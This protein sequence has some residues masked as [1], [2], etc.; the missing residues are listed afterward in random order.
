MSHLTTLQIQQSRGARRLNIDAVADQVLRLLE[1][2]CVDAS[3]Y[4]DLRGAV[5]GGEAEFALPSARVC[6]LVEQVA[7]LL[8]H[9][10]FGARGFGEEFRDTWVRE[11]ANGTVTFKQGPWAC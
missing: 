5:L 4:V 1:A 7:T 11:F 9:F 3:A 6:A 10:E 2:H 8:P